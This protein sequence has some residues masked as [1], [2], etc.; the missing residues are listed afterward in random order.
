MTTPRADEIVHQSIRLRIM[1][2]LD[3]ER[4]GNALEFPRLKAISGATDGNLGAHLGTLEGAG[5]IAL[6]KEA[7]G[8]RTRT[9][10]TITAAGRAAFRGHIAYLRA[11]L[12]AISPEAAA[13]TPDDEGTASR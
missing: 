13:Q 3:A 8:K 6:Q 2:A 7:V 12:D 1:T 5:Y 11:I 4:P 9:L 10:V